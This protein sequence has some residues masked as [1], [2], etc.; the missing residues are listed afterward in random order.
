MKDFRVS[1][2]QRKDAST[3]GIFTIDGHEIVIGADLLRNSEVQAAKAKTEARSCFKACR[4]CGSCSESRRDTSYPYRNGHNC[5][6]CEPFRF[7][8]CNNGWMRDS[9][10]EAEPFTEEAQKL[11]EDGGKPLI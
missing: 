7:H 5:I 9:Y 10:G 4:S 6:T 1:A 3:K 8:D 2:K 11:F